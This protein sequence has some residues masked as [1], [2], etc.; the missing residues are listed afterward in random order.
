MA[1][2]NSKKTMPATLTQD[3]LEQLMSDPSEDARVE[4]V[5]KIADH[6]IQGKLLRHEHG[7]AQEIF[8]LLLNDAA[9]RVREV[10]A[11]NLKECA[12][13]PHD[14]TLALA[15]DV[16]SVALPVLKYSDVL[17]DD[18]LVEIISRKVKKNKLRLPGVS[19]FQRMSLRP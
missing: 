12:G 16:E 6:F 7:M 18:D 5:T 17:T 1:P 3:D 9:V 10:M 19:S 8:R 4:T 14:V 15:N 11:Q 2:L 13:L